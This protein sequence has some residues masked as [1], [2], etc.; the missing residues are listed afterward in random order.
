MLVREGAP[1]W[2]AWSASLRE[3]RVSPNWACGVR[4]QP[5]FA[6]STT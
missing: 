6:T 4:A 2:R 5:F 3:T 1:E